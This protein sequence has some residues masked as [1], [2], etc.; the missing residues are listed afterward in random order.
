MHI[1]ANIDFSLI[2]DDLYSNQ[3]SD[4]HVAEGNLSVFK[5]LSEKEIKE[6][7][8]VPLAKLL[9]EY[10]TGDS[11]IFKIIY[12]GER[13]H[14]PFSPFTTIEYKRAYFRSV[15]QSDLVIF[16][17]YFGASDKLTDAHNFDALF[18]VPDT[19]RLMTLGDCLMSQINSIAVTLS[20]NK[21]IG[22]TKN[23]FYIGAFGGGVEFDED[24]DLNLP[25]DRSLNVIAISPFTYWGIP[26]FRLLMKGLWQ[27]RISE[28]DADHL[29]ELVLEFIEAYVGN[30]ERK[31]KAIIFLHNSAGLPWMVENK[32]LDHFPWHIEGRGDLIRIDKYLG[33]I[34][35]LIDKYVEKNGKIFLID[36]RKI[37]SIYGRDTLD[38][39]IIPAVALKDSMFHYNLFGFYVAERYVQLFESLCTV[40]SVKLLFV[41]FDNTLWSGLMA[42]GSVEHY[43]YRQKIITDLYHAGI[44]LVAL[45]KN[46][47]KNIRW[48]EM[49]INYNHFC[50][51]KINWNNKVTNIIRASKELNVSLDQAMVLDDS[52]EELGLIKF[53][54]PQV[55]VI[56]ST[57]ESS[58]DILRIL[59]VYASARYAKG[60]NRNDLY[61]DN[62]KRHAYL[63]EAKEKNTFTDSQL[64]LFSPLDIFLS[65]SLAA[66]TDVERIY[67]ILQRTNQ[68]NC[69]GKRY[70]IHQLNEILQN[71]VFRTYVFSL[72]D[73]FG[74]MGLVG[75]VFLRKDEDAYCIENF[76]L[77]CRA[78]GYF[79]EQRMLSYIIKLCASKKSIIGLMNPNGKN[80]PA[81]ALY[82]SYGFVKMAKEGEWVLSAD[83]INSLPEPKW[84]ALTVGEGVDQ[85]F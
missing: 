67:E 43:R 5:C 69:S 24:V 85:L 19:V 50:L 72:K 30:I 8:L 74:D 78:M 40:H 80:L 26:S 59:C 14:R 1:S 42:E 68:F 3:F 75:V 23:E 4:I 11:P 12:M 31:S 61:A 60:I 76:V 41:D 51:L 29:V 49:H 34:N 25:S 62:V 33:K 9:Y 32:F 44:L 82:E 27:R 84:I 54:V 56:D 21:N 46:D 52:A 53:H 38:A 22:I 2:A 6:T 15:I 37:G 16:Q 64:R 70:S 81:Q 83:N 48:S 63:D 55:K 57:Q 10:I 45:S 35:N 47:E 58:W 65:V 28:R 77:S 36:E 20:A 13:A 18:S 17:K 71:N 66:F 73:N 39:E 79:V 7:W